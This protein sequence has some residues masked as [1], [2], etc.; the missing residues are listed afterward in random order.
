MPFGIPQG[1]E[2]IT[3]EFPG[4][5]TDG[6]FGG[7]GPGAGCLLYVVTPGCA[8][9]PNA[10][11]VNVNFPLPRNVKRPGAWSSE[12]KS[13]TRLQSLPWVVAGSS[14]RL[15]IVQ[16]SLGVTFA[17][18]VAPKAWL[19]FLAEMGTRT[20]VETASLGRRP[21]GWAGLAGHFSRVREVRRLEGKKGVV[22]AA[23]AVA[24]M[25][26]RRLRVF[27]VGDRSCW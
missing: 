8:P 25:T 4:F 6:G 1:A 15:K 26:E 3:Y 14:S 13:K 27:M 11:P 24:R 21:L 18:S 16:K 20:E 12:G 9:D 2:L 5:T 19:G 10:Y 17:Q 7:L 23:K 22:G